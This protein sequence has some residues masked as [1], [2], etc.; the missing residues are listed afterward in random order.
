[1]VVSG[2]T[3]VGFIAADR[4]AEEG[5]LTEPGSTDSE[6]ANVE[7]AV[8]EKAERGLILAGVEFRVVGNVVVARV[9]I[10]SVDMPGKTIVSA[11]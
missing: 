7:T 8:L 11:V 10:E 5:V 3:V 2:D 1:V 9:A 6:I 4:D